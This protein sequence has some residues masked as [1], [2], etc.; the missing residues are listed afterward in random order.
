VDSITPRITS[1]IVMAF[2]ILSGF[3]QWRRS[4]SIGLNSSAST[5]VYRVTHQ[6]T[7]NITECGFHMMSGCQMRY[8][9]PRSNNSATT[10]RVYPRNAVNS[11]GRMIG[12]KRSMLKI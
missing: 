8:G 10:T 7:S 6:A 4:S 12:L 5:V 1:G 9:K 2:T 3:S 11:V